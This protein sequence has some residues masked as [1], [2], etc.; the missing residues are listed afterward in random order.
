MSNYELMGP[1]EAITYGRMMALEQYA[2][3]VLAGSKS[4]QDTPCPDRCLMR[5][6]TCAHFEWIG[7]TKSFPPDD[8]VS[9]L[10]EKYGDAGYRCGRCAERG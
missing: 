9:R 3:A 1:A 8:V 2:R 5:C 6:N 10:V 7:I 4:W